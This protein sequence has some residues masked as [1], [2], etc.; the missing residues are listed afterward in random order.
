VL[1]RLGLYDRDQ[2]YRLP[3][4]KV[5]TAPACYANGDA[6]EVLGS[7]TRAAT[8]VPT[9]RAFRAVKVGQAWLG[10]TEDCGGGEAC[11][12]D[13]FAAQITVTDGCQVLSR[14]AVIQKVVTRIGGRTRSWPPPTTSISAKLIKEHE[15][16]E[17][18]HTPLDRRSS[19]R[20]WAVVWT[21]RSQQSPG[22]TSSVVGWGVTAVDACTDW[23]GASSGGPQS[24]PPGWDYVHDEAS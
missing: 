12:D 13:R 10:T 3:L 17:I 6:L 4:G 18:F 5:V 8:P 20:V 16:S 19:E 2:P 23:F 15:F 7:P 11:L 24:S 14:N 9:G 21:D 22:A 1:L